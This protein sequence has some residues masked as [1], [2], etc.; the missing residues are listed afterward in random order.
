MSNRGLVK[1]TVHETT[2]KQGSKLSVRRLS[3]YVGLCLGAIIFAVAVLIFGFGGAIL[4]GYGK[5]KAERAFAQAYPGC[6]LQIGELDFSLGGNR[7]VAQS[8]TLGAT[9]AT[10]HVG[11]VTVTG[12]RWARLLWGTAAPVDVL[13][14]A[15]VEATNLNL[16]LPQAHYGI[17]CARLH[18][19]VP[20]S[21][22]IAVGTELRPLVAD[23]AFFAA[24]EFR[25]T[26]FVVVV[27]ECK[28]LGLVYDALLQGKSYRATAVHFSR[29]F[30]DALVDRDKPLKP[31][32]KSPLMVREAL[33][34]IRQPLRIDH[35]SITNGHIRYSERLVAGADPGVLTFGD[36][37]ISVEGLAN[38]GEAPAAISLRAQGALMDAG[39]LKVRM[40][41]PIAAPDFSLH[42]SGSLGA[43]DLTRLNA[44]LDITEHTRI[45]SGNAQEAAFEIDVIAG[46]AR[47]HVRAIY[48]NLVVAVLDKQ[49]GSA[50]GLG[51]R[52]TSLLANVLKVKNA[53]SAA[54][55]GALTEGKV[56]YTRRP[57]DQFLEYVWFALWSG[58]R[59]AISL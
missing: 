11:R 16:V 48:S 10:L 19:S 24:H 56:N 14:K 18:G 53:N 17:H 58:V 26:R 8:I 49:T 27:P 54:A 20:G 47:G 40:T 30:L 3:A 2:V 51:D 5:G 59:N 42:Y 45:Q 50:S 21:D 7:L 12:V 29:P 57:E 46:Q 4:N 13:A 35:L 43:M 32:V 9:N 34:A 31:F 55:S 22:L 23:E 15:S 37:S 52:L 33:D 41:I 1:D 6:A 28:V 44:F 38:R 25:T 36:V 39:T